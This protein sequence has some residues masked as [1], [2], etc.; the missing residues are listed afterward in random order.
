MCI[1][2]LIYNQKKTT[3]FPTSV[4]TKS[5]TSEEHYIQISYQISPK[6]SNMWKVWTIIHLCLQMTYSYECAHIHKTNNHST[7]FVENSV[8]YFTQIWWGGGATLQ[9]YDWN[10]M[11]IARCITT[12]RASVSSITHWTLQSFSVLL[13]HF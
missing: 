7:N 3:A 6:L 12:S 13:W 10:I 5:T 1:Y 9:H 2:N 4:F 8:P 11:W